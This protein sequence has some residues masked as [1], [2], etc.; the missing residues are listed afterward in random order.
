MVRASH[1]SAHSQAHHRQAQKTGRAGVSGDVHAMAARVA[2]S[3]AAN[4]ACGRGRTAGGSQ[5]LEGFE[6]P[7]VEWEK[8]ILPSRVANY[9]P[10]WLDRLCLSGA[11][12]WGR[13][14]PHPAFSAGNGNGPRRVIPSKAAPITF[15]LRDSA[16][17]LDL[18]LEEQSVEA[19][20]LARR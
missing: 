4:P 10:R 18:A 12:G 14:S 6:A 2:A 3:R 5:K 13:V 11:V 8:T 17:W 1:S 16:A 19:A 15:Y 20:K 7:A 9:D